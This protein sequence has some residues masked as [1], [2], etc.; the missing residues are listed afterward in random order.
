[1]ENRD[2]LKKRVLI[3]SWKIRLLWDTCWVVRGYVFWDKRKAEPFV[4]LFFLSSTKERWD[5]MEDES[6]RWFSSMSERR[7]L[8]SRKN[9]RYSLRQII[10]VAVVV[11]SRWLPSTNLG[12]YPRRITVAIV[13]G[14]NLWLSPTIRSGGCCWL[15]SKGKLN[16]VFNF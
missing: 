13:D 16:F 7:W 11:D 3:K 10:S 14:E 15:Q 9:L 12:G 4:F 1:M 6:R 8:S 5:R 2:L